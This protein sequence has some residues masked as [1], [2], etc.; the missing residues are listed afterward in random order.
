MHQVHAQ[1]TFTRAFGGEPHVVAA[2]PGRVNLIGEHTDYH[3]GFVLPMLV[4]QQTVVTVRRRADYVVRVSSAGMTPPLDDYV[5]GEERPRSSWIDYVQGV[6][7]LLERSGRMLSGFDATIESTL[8]PGGGVASSAALSVALLRAMSALHHLDLGAVEIAHLAHRV[9]TDF[10]CVPVGIMDQMACSVCRPNEALF[11]DTRSLA[12]ERLPWPAEIELIVIHSGLT[13][14]HARGEYATRRRESFAAA[15]LLQV[16]WLRDAT[17]AALNR[18]SMPDVLTRRARHV[19]TENQR[20]VDAV[21][22]LRRVDAARLGALLNQSHSSL[23]S[24]YEVTTPEVDELVAIGQRDPDVYGARMTGG[25]FGGC[26][27]MLAFPGR[28]RAAA[29]RIVGE[30]ADTI[31]RTASILVPMDN[32]T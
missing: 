30:Y 28:A 2:A 16:R 5:I 13:H 1:S 12:F 3:Q 8:P 25:G 29:E 31:G 7:W 20:V 9:E 26:V 24:D 27:V 17:E 22:A 19:I 15:S 4:P 21:A 14:S 18:T 10:V 23:R 32:P 11:L 6:T